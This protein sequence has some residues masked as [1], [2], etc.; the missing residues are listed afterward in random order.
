M[1]YEKMALLRMPFDVDKTT[2]SRKGALVIWYVL[3][4]P[5]H[6]EQDIIRSCRQ[7]LTDKA[8][9]DAFCF[10]YDRMRRY[11]GSWHVERQSMF[12]D[13]VFLESEDGERLAE[14]LEQYQS[15]LTVLGGQGALTPVCGEEEQFLRGLCDGSHHSGMSRGYIRNGHTHI[16]EGPLQGKEK[17]IRKIDRHKRLA[18]LE[19]PGN[20]RGVNVG[21]EI[22]NKV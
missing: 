2:G 3:Y 17:L 9:R 19:M 20:L 6:K 8:L 13:Y 18:K 10:T 22:Y 21:L 12:P 16:T 5:N 15:I 11:E 7:H 4:C 14:E 1:L